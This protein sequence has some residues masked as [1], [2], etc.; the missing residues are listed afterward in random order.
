MSFFEKVKEVAS[1]HPEI[2][3]QSVF[4]RSGK[5]QE[6]KYLF[7]LMHDL[8]LLDD[9]MAL[10]AEGKCCIDALLST[11]EPV[12][13]QEVGAPTIDPAESEHAKMFEVDGLRLFLLK[14]LCTQAELAYTQI[15]PLVEKI[16]API[17]KLEESTKNFWVEQLAKMQEKFSDYTALVRMVFVVSYADK[18]KIPAMEAANRMGI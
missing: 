4:S 2:F 14:D 7:M 3:A 11:A 13:P 18:L 8:N 6:C 17:P 5:N 16:I 15:Q 10:T 12:T 1:G 9:N